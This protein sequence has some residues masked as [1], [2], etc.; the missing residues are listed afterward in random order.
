M[1]RLNSLGWAT[2]ER[3]A[4]G[5]ARRVVVTF[6]GLCSL[7]AVTA[8]SAS[9]AYVSQSA[10]PV[11]GGKSCVAPT[12]STIQEAIN[13]GAGTVNVCPGTYTEQLSITKAVKLNAVN[14][15]GTATVAMPAGAGFSTTSCD[16]AVG[17]QKDE[18]SICTSGTVAITGLNVEAIV[19]TA[20]CETQIFDLNGIRVAGGGTLKATNVTINGA[21][22][23]VAGLKGCQYGLA[24]AVGDAGIEPAQ[25]GHA[26]L[27]KDTISGYQKNGPT[28]SGAG[29]T[30]TVSASTI[31]GSGPSPDT[32]QNGIQVAFGGQGTIK[33][34]TISG[35]ECNVGSCGATGEQASGVL[36]YEAATGSKVVSSKIDENDL[37]AYYASG[38]ATVP[39]TPDVTLSK[40]VFTSNRYEGVLFE[41]GKASMVKDTI[42][43]SGRVGI[44]LFQ[45]KYQNSAIESAS[46]ESKI[47]GQSEASIIVESDKDAADKAGKFTFASGTA[48]APVLI[49]ESNNFEVI[50]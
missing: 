43:G 49:N 34:S 46:T 1:R 16:L 10:P 24:V 38:S 26:I 50:F 11:A 21:S 17:E 33:T 37:G 35:N 31:T 36:F 47:T 2:A 4:P 32:A 39:A 3:V 41:E 18:I 6:A 22:T 44:D 9:A 42:N 45:A 19:P 40:D 8:A 23:S 5:R 13:A 20:G 29:S 12:Y 48:A 7:L 27:S 25:V 14:G 28:V 30:L 15:A